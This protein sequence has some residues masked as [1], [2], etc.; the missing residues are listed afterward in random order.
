MHSCNAS[1]ELKFSSGNKVL[2][3][4]LP[5][6]ASSGGGARV[7]PPP[8]IKVHSAA[9]SCAE[10]WIDSVHI[11]TNT[12][13]QSPHRVAQCRLT[14]AD[15]LK[16]KRRRRWKR[17][18]QRAIQRRQQ[19]QLQ[20]QLQSGC[21]FCCCCC[22]SW[23]SLLWLTS[24]L[25]C[26]RKREKILWKEGRKVPTAPTAD[27]TVA[28]D[29]LASVLL[30]FLAK[31]SAEGRGLVSSQDTRLPSFLCLFYFTARAGPH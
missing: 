1:S 9:V 4:H 24:S 14:A 21:V 25:N 10:S 31:N 7:A 28:R 3:S 2:F 19:Q 11:Q 16:K 27:V 23:L 15:Q 22:L 29:W 20:L 18:C 5:S 13:T 12:Q 26:Q 30:F 6:E 17:E 8:L